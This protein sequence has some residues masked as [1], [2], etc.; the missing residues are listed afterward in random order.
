MWYF[1]S[2]FM[3]F[4]F[5]C[6]FYYIYGVSLWVRIY[7]LCLVCGL[8][9]LSCHYCSLLLI[10]VLCIWCGMF[11][12]FGQ[13][14]LVGSLGILVGKFRCCISLIVWDVLSVFVSCSVLC[15]LF[16]CVSL[17]SL[18]IC[19]VSFPLYVN[20]AHFVFLFCGSLFV[21]RIIVLLSRS[22]LAAPS[23]LTLYFF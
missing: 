9:I 22:Q 20:M 19:L 12:L 3:C 4:P 18:A 1:S 10:C 17:N 2:V 6:G 14:I 8:I 13:C 15:K 16:W 5:L 23:T 11:C 7:V 21:L